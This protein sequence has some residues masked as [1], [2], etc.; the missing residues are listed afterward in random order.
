MTQNILTYTKDTQG[1]TTYLEVFTLCVSECKVL[2]VRRLL[3]S[4]D[5]GLLKG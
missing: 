4:T 2:S 5:G 1:I 3:F